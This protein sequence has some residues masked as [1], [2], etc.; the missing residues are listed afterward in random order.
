MIANNCARPLL[1][2]THISTKSTT[3]VLNTDCNE[4]G[5]TS[6]FGTQFSYYE[7][8][9]KQRHERWGDS[10]VETSYGHLKEYTN[11]QGVTYY[12]GR[13]AIPSEFKVDKNDINQVM[14]RWMTIS[15]GKDP[16]YNLYYPEISICNAVFNV[17]EADHW[18]SLKRTYTLWAPDGRAKR[19]Q[20]KRTWTNDWYA[21]DP[22]Q[23]SWDFICKH[24]TQWATEWT[25]SIYGE[26]RVWRLN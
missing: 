11:P 5:K 9:L 24:Q 1:V 23:T 25:S 16:D 12:R 4:C 2:T 15:A 21:F 10:E 14:Q 3:A 18:K 20:S 19:Q 7:F 13:A 26:F 6:D 8:K 17:V 22:Y